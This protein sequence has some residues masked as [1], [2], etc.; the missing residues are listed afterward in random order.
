MAQPWETANRQNV[1][2]EVRAQLVDLANALSYDAYYGDGLTAE[3][4]EYDDGIGEIGYDDDYQDYDSTGVY[5]SFLRAPIGRTFKISL[6]NQASANREIKLFD[7]TP[8]PQDVVETPPGRN[9]RLV[10]WARGGRQMAISAF[11]VGTT[12]Q[13]ARDSLIFEIGQETPFGGRVSNE[14]SPLDFATEKDYLTTLVTMPVAFVID[15][16]TY[17]KFTILANDTIS[18]TY[19]LRAITDPARKLRGVRPAI[20]VK[21]GLVSVRPVQPK[22]RRRLGSGRGS[23][24]ATG[25]K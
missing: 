23:Y 14:I 9:E 2:D 3:V 16:F 25:R 15:G 13:A 17:F 7:G 12:S 11:K 24:R 1:D 5:R 6:T 4:I 22:P 8:I 19:Y 20:P 21:D 10:T 18:I